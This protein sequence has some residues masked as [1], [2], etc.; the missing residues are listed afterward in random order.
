MWSLNEIS[1]LP[2]VLYKEG[3]L[4][5]FSKFTDEQKKQS[6]GFVQSRSSSKAVLRNF[7]KFTD[8]YFAR[9]SFLIKL[10]TGVSEPAVQ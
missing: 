2:E 8:N 10:H 3:D 9:A 1:N 6:S 4:K 7:A 5:N